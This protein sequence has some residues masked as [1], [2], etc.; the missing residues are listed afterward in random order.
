[1]HAHQFVSTEAGTLLHDKI[2]FEPP[3]GLLGRMITANS[4]QKDLEKLIA[5]RQKMLKEIFS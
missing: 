5:H 3:G 1:M 2:D 4:I